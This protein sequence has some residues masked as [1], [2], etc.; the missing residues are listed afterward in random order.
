MLRVHPVGVRGRRVHADV[1]LLRADLHVAE[2]RHEARG[3]GRGV[4]GAQDTHIGRHEFRVHRARHILRVHSA[5]RLSADRRH[6]VQDT[7]G[8]RVPDQLVRQPVPVHHTHGQ[9]QARRSLHVHQ[10]SIQRRQ[11]PINGWKRSDERAVRFFFLFCF[12]VV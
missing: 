12:R 11:V 5:A 2:L 8:V 9:V 6:Q 7:A 10:V 3:K 4:G 1:V